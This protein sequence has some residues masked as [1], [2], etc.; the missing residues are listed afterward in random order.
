M[1]SETSHGAGRSRE[2]RLSATSFAVLG[3]LSLQEWTTY[4]LAQQMRRS[5]S[6]FW[7][8]AERRIYDEPKRLADAGY[9]R[10]RHE[11]VGKRPRTCWTI[12][13]E[14]RAAL[15]EWLAQPPAAPSLEFEGML[16]VFL[17]QAADK[18]QLLATLAGIADTA[19]RQRHAL[20]RM[21]DDLAGD[22][23]QFPQR[24][25]INALAME[26]MLAI[27]ELT[28]QWARHAQQLAGEWRSVSSPGPTA[29]AR[30]RDFFAE[31]AMP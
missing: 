30:A 27:T 17:A 8:R 28:E 9:V 29:R 20:A 19:E 3:L 21:C 15:A 11:V 4:E 12:T 2:H 25:H 6:Y 31:H 23:G 7:P 26:F 10:A 24:M 18:K 16:K 5:F 14:G 22:G 1:A 13:D